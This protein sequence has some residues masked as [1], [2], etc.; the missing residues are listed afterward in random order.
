MDVNLKKVNF[1]IIL[2]IKR[3]YFIKVNKP[4]KDFFNN[5]SDQDYLSIPNKNWDLK[6]ETLIYLKSDIE[7]LLEIILK[8]RNNI[9][10][11]YRLD[12]TKFKTLPELALAI[13][14]SNYVPNNLKSKFKMIKGNL[15]TLIRSAYFGGNVDVFINKI[16]NGF[17]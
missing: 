3:I 4:S 8:F 16:S 14:T 9:N 6:K 13:Y 15:E 1:P 10:E 12:I 7:G 11:K 17:Y 5:I 2:L